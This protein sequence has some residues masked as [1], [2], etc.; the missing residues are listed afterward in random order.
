L[1]KNA[2]PHT[3]RN[4]PYTTLFASKKHDATHINKQKR[5]TPIPAAEPEDDA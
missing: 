2:K 5:I 1:D 4:R 3:K